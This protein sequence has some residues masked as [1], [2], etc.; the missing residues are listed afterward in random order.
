MNAV[1]SR[2]L[3]A[4]IAA[5]VLLSGRVNAIE[6]GQ[7]P[8]H[9]PGVMGVA[10]DNCAQ[11]NVWDKNKTDKDS[12][13]EHSRLQVVELRGWVDGYMTAMDTTQSDWRK[14]VANR[15]GPFGPTSYDDRF[16]GRV[17]KVLERCRQYPWENV[18]SAT[19]AARLLLVDE[20]VRSNS[21]LRAGRPPPP[22]PPD[23]PVKGS[24][25]K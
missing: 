21:A 17:D 20:P 9:M 15:A 25:V 3:I 2:T 7:D 1:H 12:W 19:E 5:V 16:T 11:V 22:A 10:A 14:R 24:K 8:Y 23:W 18:A 6:P 13:G 4:T